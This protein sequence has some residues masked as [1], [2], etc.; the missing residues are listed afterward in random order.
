VANKG[1]EAI[2]RKFRGLSDDAPAEPRL[3]RSAH[4][5][6][7]SDVS[8]REW[9]VVSF[10][11]ERMVS[12]LEKFLGRRMTGVVEGFVA[13]DLAKFPPGMIDDPYGVEKI[14]RGEG[15]CI[16]SRLGPQRHARLYSCADHGVI[17]HECVHGLCHLT[18]GSTG[19]TWLAE[20]L[21]E[22]GS[23]WKDGEQAI[24]LPTPVID[25]LQ[26]ATPKRKL[27]EIAVPGRTDAGT[28]Q[29]YAWRWALCHLLKQTRD[30]KECL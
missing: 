7:L 27:L 20:G 11:L 12:A 10:K 24:D 8:D 6:F 3:V 17:Q 4:F 5:A 15:V 9:A 29:D 13:R 1:D 30:L 18:F 25:Y 23:Y 26:N 21:A 14:S 28:W 22:L 19:P 2:E 16:N